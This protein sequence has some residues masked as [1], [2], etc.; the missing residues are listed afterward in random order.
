MGELRR[1]SLSTASGNAPRDSQWQCEW[2]SPQLHRLIRVRLVSAVLSDD[3]MG[4]A[5]QFSLFH[6]CRFQHTFGKTIILQGFLV[7][8]T[9]QNCCTRVDTIFVM[10][11]NVSK[12][13]STCALILSETLALYKSFTYLLTLYYCGSHAKAFASRAALHDASD[14]RP[15][16]NY[17]SSHR[18]TSNQGIYALQLRL[19]SRWTE[20]TTTRANSSSCEL[21]Q[22]S[23]H[24]PRLIRAGRRDS[25][26]ASEIREQWWTFRKHE[27]R[28]FEISYFTSQGSDWVKVWW[29]VV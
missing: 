3:A 6:F 14:E 8:I 21:P 4:V 19:A 22:I 28:T 15:N 18:S 10:Q 11:C 29:W 16:N 27:R 9:V 2:H 5:F 7:K 13:I 17:D 20:T 1:R 12:R 26:A 23:P 24:F 25:F